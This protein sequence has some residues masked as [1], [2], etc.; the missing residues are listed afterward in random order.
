MN[1]RIAEELGVRQQLR[2]IEI[3]VDDVG[4]RVEQTL[5]SVAKFQVVGL[6]RTLEAIW[7][8]GDYAR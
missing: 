1:L 2:A 5:A 7:A 4:V 6:H 8:C 3:H